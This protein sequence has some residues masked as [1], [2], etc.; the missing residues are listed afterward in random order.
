MLRLFFPCIF[1]LLL[2]GCIS[3]QPYP[4]STPLA[5]PLN[6][7]SMRPPQVGQQWIYQIRN[8]FNQEIV[9]VVTETVVAISPQIRIERIGKKFG[10][11]PEE[12]Q[13]P[14]G[15]V[16]Q[17]PQWKPAQRFEQ[18]LPLW[19]EK[20]IP[21]WSNFYRTRYQVPGYPSASYYWG[22]S[23][24][25]LG[26]ESISVPAGQFKVLKYHNENPYFESNDVFRVGN[27]REEDVWL[28][29][30]IG[31]WVI[32]RSSGRYI[33]LGVSWSNAYWDDYL[34]WELISWK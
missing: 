6:P 18:A 4:T 23:I 20:L 17:D 8:V 31:R 13:E 27:Y 7:P 12:I 1:S 15:Y 21:E 22:L 14:W 25:A 10:P 16:V 26:W 2:L 28:A 33:T 29:P 32:R 34:E 30:E 9:D 19:P 11:L 3:S 24:K 5:T